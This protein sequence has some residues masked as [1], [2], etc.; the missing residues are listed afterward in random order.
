M[1]RG[2]RGGFKNTPPEQMLHAALKAV[3]DRAKAD[4]KLVEDVAVGN[5]L[6]PAAGQVNARMA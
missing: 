5:A 4:P 1:A 3:I 2:K 6:Q